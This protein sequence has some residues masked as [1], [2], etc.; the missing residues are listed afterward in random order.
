[1]YELIAVHLG[2]EQPVI[3]VTGNKTQ[4]SN[5]RCLLIL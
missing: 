2:V 1:M 4:H 5:V 3:N